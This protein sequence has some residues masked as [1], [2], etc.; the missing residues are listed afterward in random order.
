MQIHFL[1]CLSGFHLIPASYSDK[2]WTE[3]Q[4][5]EQL[6]QM[7]HLLRD[8]DQYKLRLLAQWS[9]FI[10]HDMFWRTIK[11]KWYKT[12]C[13]S[14]LQTASLK[15][16]RQRTKP[17][18]RVDLVWAEVQESKTGFLGSTS[19]L[20]AVRGIPRQ[21]HG[22]FYQLVLCKNLYDLLV[23]IMCSWPVDGNF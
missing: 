15:S 11:E 21:K 6:S 8:R 10:P 13:D 7:T 18:Q 5:N 3:H 17:S 23:D 12:K 2:Q 9:L 14:D 19:V 1:R 4:E 20:E 16:C 22:S